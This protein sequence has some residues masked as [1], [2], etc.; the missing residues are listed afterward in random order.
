[1]GEPRYAFTLAFDRGYT[2]M[3]TALVHALRHFHPARTIR[4]FTLPDDVAALQRWSERWPEVSVHAYRQAHDL[5]F[6][7]WHPLIW[8][9]LE[10]FAADPA[11]L[12]VVLDVDQILYRSLEPSIA[13]A[14]RAG[15]AVAASPDITD[16]RGHVHASFGGGRGLDELVGVPCFN[17]GAMVVRPSPKAYGELVAL[18]RREHRHVRLPEQAILN[19]WARAT[20]SH[21]DLG[22]GFM[23]Q[24]WSP[25]LLERP[26]TSCLVH[27]WTPRPAFFGVSPRRSA[28][29]ELQECLTAYA[30][31]T[32]QPYPLEHLERDFLVRLRGDLGGSSAHE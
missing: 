2:R 13:E 14:E 21:H 4:V 24:P 25:R 29:P 10:A 19:L 17:A 28:E 16:L 5:S 20:E 18:A 31:Q 8:A 1:M 26:I 11:E 3:A 27:F 7:E 12:Q 23:L 9:K 15:R 32:G 6:G 22:E 30:R